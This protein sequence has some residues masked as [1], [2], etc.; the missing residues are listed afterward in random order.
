MTVLALNIGWVVL[1]PPA[2]LR[3]LLDGNRPLNDLSLQ[4][5][6]TSAAAGLEVL[7]EFVVVLRKVSTVFVCL[8][9]GPVF[10]PVSGSK[11]TRTSVVPTEWTPPAGEHR[12]ADSQHLGRSN[13]LDP[14]SSLAS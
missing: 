14:L 7:E 9:L 10:K 1:L 4:R 5:G 12:C 13:W 3:L 11:S 6:T 8:Q 2:A